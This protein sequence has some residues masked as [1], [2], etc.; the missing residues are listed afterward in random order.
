[1]TH[2]T[3]GTAGQDRQDRPAA[4]Q[5][6]GRAGAWLSQVPYWA[7]VSGMAG[8]L[9]WMRGGQRDVRSGTL[10]MAGVLLAG[11]AARLVLPE[12]RA[13]LLGAR[14][15]LVDAALLAA[16]GVGLLVAGLVF[17]VPT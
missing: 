16:L 14:Q 15:R 5:P 7:V 4:R 3:R 2:P 13:G 12:H 11:A 1:M 9:L 10:V 6:A 8:A 17:P